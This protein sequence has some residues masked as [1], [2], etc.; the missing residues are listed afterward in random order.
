MYAFYCLVPYVVVITSSGSSIASAAITLTCSYSETSDNDSASFQWF[1]GPSNNRSQLTSDDLLTI[2][3]NSSISQ[4]HISSLRASHAGSYTCRTTVR[5]IVEEGTETIN[6]NCKYWVTPLAIHCVLLHLFLHF[7]PSS[8]FCDNYSSNW[9]SN[10]WILSNFTCSVELSPVVDVPVTVSTMWTGP[11]G[12]TSTY[13]ARP[14]IGSTTN[15]T[16]IVLINAVRNGNYTCKASMSHS[17]HF[18]SD[19]TLSEMATLSVGKPISQY[20][21]IDSICDRICKKGPF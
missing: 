1:K 14:V 13:L 15:Y 6:I 7:S 17:L 12:Y 9:S 8:G 5:N 2:H 18:T 10:C 21:D 4:L 19:G 20:M 16:V 3:S 11:A